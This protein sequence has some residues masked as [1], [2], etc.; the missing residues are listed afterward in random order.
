MML[1]MLW[2]AE[3]ANVV[4]RKRVMTFAPSRRP[5]RGKMI[6]VALQYLSPQE[7]QVEV[8][9]ELRARKALWRADPEILT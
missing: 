7:L 2:A 5:T 1:E 3:L 6:D 9:T 4:T 8:C